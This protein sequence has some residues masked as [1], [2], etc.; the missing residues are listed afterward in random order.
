MQFEMK[1]TWEKVKQ[2]RRLIIENGGHIYDDNSFVVDGVEGIYTFNST[3]GLFTV[4][5]DKK[6]LLASWGMIERKLKEFF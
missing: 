6:P 5:I 4:R 2:G 3:T 1:T